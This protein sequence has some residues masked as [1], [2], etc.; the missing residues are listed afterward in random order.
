MLTLFH[1]FL[2]TKDRVAGSRSGPLP[3]P[4]VC[5]VAC[6]RGSPLTEKRRRRSSRSLLTR[7]YPALRVL[8]V[9]AGVWVARGFPSRS[10][11]TARRH[12]VGGKGPLNSKSFAPSPARAG[13]ARPEPATAGTAPRRSANPSGWSLDGPT[14]CS[15]VGSS[16]HLPC[17]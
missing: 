13:R 3:P 9:E 10:G 17:L 11:G 7:T 1:E 16:C 15:F 14:L 12:V 2:E 6:T 5:A 4:A 8:S